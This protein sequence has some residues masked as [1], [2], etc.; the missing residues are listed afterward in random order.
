[1]ASLTGLAA[2][3]HLAP[4]F[5]G[6]V[7]YENLGDLHVSKQGLLNKQVLLFIWQNLG[8]AHVLVLEWSPISF[9]ALYF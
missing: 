7:R 5:R 6:G 3:R 2:S 4:A 9:G 1:M 8:V